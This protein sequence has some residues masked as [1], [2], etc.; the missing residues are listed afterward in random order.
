MTGE[1]QPLTR[2]DELVEIANESTGD[3][4]GRYDSLPRIQRDEQ[5]AIDAMTAYIARPENE[6]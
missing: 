2:T 4:L 3:Q 5:V 1:Q 6:L